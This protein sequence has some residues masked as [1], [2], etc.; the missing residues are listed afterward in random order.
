MLKLRPLVRAAP[1]LKAARPAKRSFRAM[2]APLR[3]QAEKPPQEEESKG[4]AK[5]SPQGP[6]TLSPFG[7]EWGFPTS[8]GRMSQVRGF[9]R[10]GR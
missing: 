8:F 4:L 1:A 3:A 5:Q 10:R 7:E 6:A 2:S 9:A